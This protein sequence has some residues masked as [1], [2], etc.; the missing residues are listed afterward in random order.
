MI[1]IY[2]LNM[3]SPERNGHKLY[4]YLSEDEKKE[5]DEKVLANANI[6]DYDIYTHA[7][8]ISEK[9]MVTDFVKLFLDYNFLIKDD[10]WDVLHK[11]NGYEVRFI[12]KRVLPFKKAKK[13]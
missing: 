12:D 13:V 11:I 5:F 7:M 3:F 9:N 8:P 4:N 1:T 6:V 10:A 2:I